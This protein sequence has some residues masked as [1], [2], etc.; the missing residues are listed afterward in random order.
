M[1]NA[2]LIDVWGISCEIAL[3]WMWLDF[4][5]KQSTLVQVIGLGAISG[6]F[7]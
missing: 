5:D 6:P 1:F 3:I 4:T 2:I 7:Y